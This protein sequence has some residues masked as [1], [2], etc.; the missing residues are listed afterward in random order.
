M[1]AP[2][3]IGIEIKRTSTPKVT[4]SMR[5]AIAEL[6]LDHLYVVHPGS[7]SFPLS[8][9]V[10]AVAASRVTEPRGWLID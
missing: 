9:T 1:H 4:P 10:T 7:E 8:D 2:R 5:L 3:A 6:D